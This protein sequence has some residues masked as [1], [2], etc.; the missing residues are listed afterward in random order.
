MIETVLV[1]YASRHGAT[2]G[3]AERI[4]ARLAAAGLDAEARHVDA[5]SGLDGYDA[6]VLGAP[7]YDQ[8]WPPE[9]ES[10][11]HRHG[12]AL[13][14]RP[15]WLFSVGS[16]GDT[17]PLIGPLMQCEPHGIAEL[18]LQLGARSYRVFAG[19]IRREQWPF[20]SRQFFHVFG[21]RMGDNRDWPA[22]DAWADNIAASL[23]VPWSSSST[24]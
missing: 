19:A 13:A 4:A 20:W 24:A 9:A 5:V 1:A 11:A 6:V 16:F 7:V 3:V 17:K 2:Q 14:E 15:L 8:H 12:A 18:R 23:R 21:G 10:F 22:I